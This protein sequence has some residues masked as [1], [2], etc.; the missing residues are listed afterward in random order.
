MSFSNN[1]YV[2]QWMCTT[3][4]I[5]GQIIIKDCE[6]EQY[7]SLWSF[8]WYND[9]GPEVD[10]TN[11]VAL[12]ATSEEIITIL[13]AGKAYLRGRLQARFLLVQNEKKNVAKQDQERE[14][15]N[16]NVKKDDN[17]MN[18]NENPN[19]SFFESLGAPG[20]MESDDIPDKNIN[21]EDLLS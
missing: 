12:V 1:E 3:E 11:Y 5:G 6:C 4:N 2:R 7:R 15:K 17:E 13:N 18:G 8:F 9:F 20:V 16:A 19:D 10:K 21:F 14:L